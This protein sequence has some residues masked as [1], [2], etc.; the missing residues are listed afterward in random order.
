[1]IFVTCLIYILFVSTSLLPSGGPLESRGVL[2]CY[3]SKNVREKEVYRVYIS[4][5]SVVGLY[6]YPCLIFIGGIGFLVLSSPDPSIFRK[7]LLLV[8]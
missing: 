2:S 8:R 6:G 5:S 3:S 4:T 1:M 7:N